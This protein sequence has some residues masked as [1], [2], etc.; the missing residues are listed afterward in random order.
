MVR[1]RGRV[2]EAEVDRALDDGLGAAH[3]FGVTV[4]REVPW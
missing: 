3:D 1:V 4:G 2:S